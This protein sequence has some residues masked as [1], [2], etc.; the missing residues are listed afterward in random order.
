MVAKTHIPVL[1]ILSISEG[2]NLQLQLFLILHHLG[3]VFCLRSLLTCIIDEETDIL[4]N[5]FFDLGS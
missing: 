3:H 2:M 4:G 5:P 1:Q